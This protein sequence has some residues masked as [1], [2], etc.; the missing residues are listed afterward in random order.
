MSAVRIL[1]VDDYPENLLALEAILA[2]TGHT[3]VRAN[4]GREALK[5]L[6][7]Q[8]FA[9][10]LMDVAMP[11]LDGY[12]TAVL[13]RGRERSRL[14]PI[15]FL[16]ANNKTDAQVFKGYS[17]GAV[18]YLF[19]PFVPE[20]LLSKVAIFVELFTSRQTLEQQRTALEHSYAEMEKRVLE[21]T[22]DLA[23]ANRA[24]LAEI[25]E[26]RRVEHEREQL[27]A[28]EQAARLEAEA[29]NRM[30]DEF[31][32]TLSHEL[33]TP[34]NAILGWTH[35]LEIGKRDEAS[36]AHATRV[37]KS[38]ALAQ[39]QL[40]ADILDVSRII[41]GK[42]QLFIG[43][44][45]LC[46][47]IEATME[48]LQP[49]ADAKGITVETEWPEYGATLHADQDRLR[50][51]MWNLLSNAI[52]FTPAGGRVRVVLEAM[53]QEIRIA[54]ID[55]GQ[56]IDPAFLPHVFDRFTQADS[57]FARS[58]GGLGL[59]LAIVRHLLEL[60]GGC[61]TVASDGKDQGTTFTVTLP[62]RTHVE[63]KPDPRL[64]QRS[65]SRDAATDPLPSLEGVSVLIVDDEPDA[66]E[67][68]MLVLR[69]QGAMVVAVG[70]AAAALRAL[71]KAVPDVLVSDIGMPG[72][73]GLTLMK[74]VRS[75][76][77]EEGGRLPAVALTAYATEGDNAKAL[78][79]GFNRHLAKPIVP[80]EIVEVV[81]A[82]AS[83]GRPESEPEA[84][85][86]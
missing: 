4:S 46:A 64:E 28:R 41:G 2:D 80:A 82:L 37:I 32:G 79:A 53:P 74:K 18:D 39:A 58:H 85:Q 77:V 68:L 35:L 72:Q 84:H 5:A 14:T 38:N 6:L 44:V 42:L 10:I 27:L 62:V 15:I 30:K 11:E 59:G 25:V 29:M 36:I 20:V 63:G 8:D 76:G 61:I 45:D 55:N 50:Q 33:R 21:R 12:E 83:P 52:K 70:S 56:G 9:L 47:M 66:R 81:A 17:V 26:R 3:I 65:T 22:D 86:S 1:I 48:T 31:L 49:A 69:E 67:V 40:V 57:S 75:L 19:K 7:T 71:K 54:V 34:L 43:A 24:L 51:V 73:D 16:T 78:E 60:H 23:T 13:I